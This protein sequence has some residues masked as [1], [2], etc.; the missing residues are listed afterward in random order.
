MNH[1]LL[2][3]LDGSS[4]AEC[5]LPHVIAVAPALDAR[6]TLLQV[7]E[8]PHAESQGQAIDP[9]DWHL[10]KREARAYLD[11]IVSL[12]KV[13]GVEAVPVVLEGPPAESVIE[14]AGASDISLIVLST[15]GRSGLSEWNVSSIV[16]KIIA[17]S[18][19][20]SLLVRAGRP[21]HTDQ[22]SPYRNFF[23]GLDGSARA[24]YILPLALS[25]ARHHG[26]RLVLGMAIRKPEI[27]QRFPPT[28]DD[29]DLVNRLADRNHREA[30][31][32]FKKLQAQL[33]VQGIVPH[34]RLVVSE[35]PTLALHDMVEAENTDLVM[36]VAHGRTGE[37][38]WPYGSVTTSF[39]AHSSASLLIMQ[40]FSENEARE[41]HSA[42][43]SR[44][45][46]GH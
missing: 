29:L 6:V 13:K 44:E 25:L 27:L 24:E 9:L 43:A 39:I 36:L 7:L 15:H 26:A 14:Y 21:I 1:H 37:I 32:Y 31:R 17:R 22:T 46:G 45:V 2:V 18:Y 8:T 10:R 35:N 40:D 3:P 19:K 12:L 41:V 42:V 28:P 30:T 16:Q 11:S 34:T 5:V 23:I 33:E 4:L 38:R 20:S